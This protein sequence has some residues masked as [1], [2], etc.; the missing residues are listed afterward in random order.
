MKTMINEAPKKFADPHKHTYMGKSV[1]INSGRGNFIR[2]YTPCVYPLPGHY[3]RKIRK[4]KGF[5]ITGNKNDFGRK[6]NN[7]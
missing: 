1:I 5:I 4:L 7:V 6:I 3:D 2:K